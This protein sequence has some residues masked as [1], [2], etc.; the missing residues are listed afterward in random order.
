MTGLAHRP[1]FG[2]QTTGC[3]RAAESTTP[4]ITTGLGPNHQEQ[5]HVGQHYRIATTTLYRHASIRRS[6]RQAQPYTGYAFRRGAPA[7]VPKTLRSST[8]SHTKV[9]FHHGISPHARNTRRF[10]GSRQYRDSGFRVSPPHL[11][12]AASAAA[13]LYLRLTEEAMNEMAVA[14][15]EAAAANDLLLKCCEPRALCLAAALTRTSRAST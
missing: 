3:I 11:L 12:S 9:A 7:S 2:L 5:A 4:S 10:R 6:N 15:A 13:W 14:K 1:E 8:P